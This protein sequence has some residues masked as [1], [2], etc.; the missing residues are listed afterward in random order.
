MRIVLLAFAL[1][2][3]RS[4]ARAQPSPVAPSCDADESRRRIC[5]V[6]DSLRDALIRADT[7][8]LARLY[9]DELLTTN[10]RGVSST[11]VALL[12]AIGSGALRFDTLVVHERTAEVHGDTAVVTGRMHQVARGAEGAHPLE[13]SYARTYV[14]RGAGWQLVRATIRRA[15]A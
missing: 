12:R 2:L 1:A 9:A 14:R 6:D 13:V 8:T 3:S 11:K 4:A 7:T 15:A 10:Y 5:A